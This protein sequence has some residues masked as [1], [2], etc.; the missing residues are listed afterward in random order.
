MY[1][2]S[3]LQA[4]DQ[5]LQNI[6]D[7]ELVLP[8]LPE[9]AHKVQHMID[10]INFSADQIVAVISG[11]PAISAQVIKTANETLPVGKPKVDT[12]RAAV[13]HLGYKAFRNLMTGIVAFSHQA[14]SE[15]PVVNIQLIDFWEHS[16]QVATYSYMLARNL[17][18]LDPHQAMLAGLVHDIGF[19]PLCLHAEETTP[20]L[21]HETL[22]DLNKKFRA[23]VSEKLLH[24]WNFPAAIIEAATGHE[25]L[26]RVSAGP[27]A[28]Y[29]DVVAV[30]NL[31]NHTS[32][33]QTDW[34]SVAALRKLP[35][36]PAACPTFHKQNHDEIR[37]TRKMLFSHQ[38]RIA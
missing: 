25:D 17:K 3:P 33:K 37:A 29:T 2:S 22:D 20:S 30:A 32:A 26:H 9:I 16:R 8:T 4:L 5:L 23:A 28:S 14:R 6:E 24:A 7:S 21:D 10:D 19:L 27:N 15:H 13:S 34:E 35:L 18:H 1:I 31:L 38:P 11:D 36:A 12:I